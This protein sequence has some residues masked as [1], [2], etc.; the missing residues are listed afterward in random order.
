VV[1]RPVQLV[2]GAGAEGGA[3]LGAVEGNPDRAQLDVPVVSDVA[4]IEAPTGFS[5]RSR[6]AETVGFTRPR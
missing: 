2:D 5:R 3:Y 1:Q 6:V 4:E